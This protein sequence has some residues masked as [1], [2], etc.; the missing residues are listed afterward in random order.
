MTRNLPESP[1]AGDDDWR[2]I[3]E[4]LAA[5][6]VTALEELYDA[7]AA[8]LHD[9]ALWRTGSLEDA[10]DVVQDVFVRV[11]RLGKRLA[12]VRNPRAWLLTVTHRAAVDVTR[13]A[14]RRRAQAIETCSFLTAAS[15]D[16][17][18]ALDAERASRLLARLPASQRTVI[19]LR[20]FA[21]L[22]FAEIGHIV[23]VPKFTAASRYR[24]GM[25]RLRRLMEGK[26]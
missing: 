17:D 21:S 8:R 18:R 22:T 26:P 4:A 16:S 10:A 9:L 3:F 23:G 24:S 14:K 1:P 12:R 13:R 7:A 20:H 15:A 19:Y 6:R 25:A 2:R 5:G 11:A